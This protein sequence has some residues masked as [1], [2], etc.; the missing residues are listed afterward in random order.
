MGWSQHLRRTIIVGEKWVYPVALDIRFFFAVY[1]TTG[2]PRLAEDSFF[3][4]C[5]L[6][7]ERAKGECSVCVPLSLFRHALS[8]V[9]NHAELINSVHHPQNFGARRQNIGIPSTPA[10]QSLFRKLHEEEKI[11]A[12]K[13]LRVLIQA[14]W[15]FTHVRAP[16]RFCFSSCGRFARSVQEHV[17][18]V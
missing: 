8:D 9:M 2:L 14:T 1:A 10:C 12:S 7:H 18:G 15:N 17:V 5:Y 16:F 4:R 11:K 3:L 13:G 6:R